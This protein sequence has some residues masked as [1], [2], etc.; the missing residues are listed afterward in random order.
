MTGGEN[1]RKETAKNLVGG[2]AVRSDSG[3]GTDIQRCFFGK[4]LMLLGLNFL[5]TVLNKDL[6][7]AMMEKRI[8]EDEKGVFFAYVCAGLLLTAFAMIDAKI[9]A[10]RINRK[11]RDRD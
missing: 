2:C 11:L 1:E 4:G 6:A 7:E 3:V 10:E 9:G 8:A 5:I